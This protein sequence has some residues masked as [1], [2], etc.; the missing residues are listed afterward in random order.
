MV[1]I[2]AQFCY[3]VLFCFCCTSVI[4]QVIQVHRIDNAKEDLSGNSLYVQCLF[5]AV[6]NR[7]PNTFTST[8]RLAY[9]TAYPP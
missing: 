2:F 5:W 7:V 8:L 6:I 4:F 9:I 1:Y 3:P